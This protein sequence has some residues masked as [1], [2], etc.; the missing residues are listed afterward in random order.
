VDA[1]HPNADQQTAR[2]AGLRL[3]A[4]A[5]FIALVG[6]AFSLLPHAKT[7]APPVATI[8][9]TLP[10]ISSDPVVG[11]GFSVAADPATHDV[12]LFGGL[13]SDARTW[14]LNDQSWTLAHPRSSP[15]D[16]SGAAAAYDPATKMV[17]L[18][19]GT[20]AAGKG[21]ND[22]WGWNGSTWRRLNSGSNGPPAG[23]GAQM[24]W[25]ATAGDMVLVTNGQ[26]MNTAETWVWVQGKS[27]GHW[28]REPKGNLAVSVFGDVMASDPVSKTLLLVSLVAPDNGESTAQTWDGS[29]WQVITRSGPDIGAM[30]YN[31][32][33][34]ALL[35][36]GLSMYSE[37]A[38]V[39][40]KCWQWTGLSWLEELLANPPPDSK[41]IVIEAEVSDTANSRLIM[42]GWLTRAIPGQ[43]QPLRTWA[44]DGEQWLVLR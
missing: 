22:T 44:W 18:F 7:A 37:S 35:A 12:V 41:Q 28:R 32:T 10:P 8:A 43:P 1:E 26:T 20:L 40:S 42:F 19:G 13:N 17:M 6:V 9:P 4:V 34:N 39:I 21:V 25:D 2:R 27:D 24:A 38:E 31:T 11:L 3:A 23:Q 30:A 5:G 36:C 16:R 33:S 14:L 15:A 29:S